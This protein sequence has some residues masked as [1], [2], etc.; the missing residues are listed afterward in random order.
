MSQSAIGRAALVLTTN[1]TGL[2]SGLDQAGQQA[3]R[4][5][6]ATAGDVNSR[7]KNVGKDVGKGGFMSGLAAAAGRVAG[8]A[9]LAIAGVVGVTKAVETL[10]EVARA[11]AAAKAFGLTAEQF[12]GMAGVARSVGEGQREFI[13]SLVTLGKVASEGA[14]GKGE[15]A[16]AWFKSLNLDAQ[17]FKQLRLDEQFFTVFEAIKQ[18]ED[19]AERVRSLMVAFGEDGGKYLLPL[20]SKSSAEIRQMA[21]GF[22]IST[23][24]V[25]KATTANQAMTR[26]GSALSSAWRQ[27]VV[28]IA[29]VV[30]VIANVITGLRPVF[31][32]L[33]RALG[34]YAELWSAVATEVIGFVR[35][36]VD[37]VGGWVSSLLGLENTTWTVKD[38]VVGAFRLV[39]TAAALVWD[40]LKAGAGVLSIAFGG[41]LKILA[42]VIDALA[43][44]VSLAKGLPDAI[45]PA[46]VNDFVTGIDAARAAVDRT[47]EGLLTWG[48]D[49]ITGFGNSAVQFNGWLDRVSK[50][51]RDQVKADAAEAV[52]AAGQVAAAV[53]LTKFDNAALIKGSSAEVSA[54]IRHD[55]AGKTAQDRMLEEQRRANKH[56]GGIDAGVKKLNAKPAVAV[57][58]I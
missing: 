9:A 33:G 7:L 37:S 45:R 49:A 3:R 17:Q 27:I 13:E 51:T 35:G 11:G 18:I 1:G 22:Q 21:A 52:A 5:A 8:P 24:E 57:G 44:L 14:A 20:L 54:R 39:G 15:V 2:R 29:P 50:K 43:G 46:W 23:N 16:T 47:G 34:A 4:W 25:E 6:D 42:L 10:D 28:A 38:V 32:W 56:L 36:I 30:E 53:R 41:V 40:T 55:F 19:P 26:A 12:T 48:R 58:A 31:D